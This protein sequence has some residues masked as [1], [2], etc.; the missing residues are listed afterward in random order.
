MGERGRGD[1]EGL[2]M[3]LGLLFWDNENVPKLFYGDSCTVL[4]ILKT[5]ELYT[6]KRSSSWYMNAISI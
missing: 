4:N 2:L 3:G 5:T 6:L 1:G